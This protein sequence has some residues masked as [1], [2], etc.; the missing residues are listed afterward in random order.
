MPSSF[1]TESVLARFALQATQ[2]P[3]APAVCFGGETLTYAE[4]ERRANRLAHHLRSL[5]LEREGVVGIYLERTPAMVVAG[6][7][8]VEGRW[9]LPP[10]R[11]RPGRRRD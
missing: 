5:G 3:D 6:L 7:G 8:R 11:S 2:H 1:A 4:L 9:G 10:A